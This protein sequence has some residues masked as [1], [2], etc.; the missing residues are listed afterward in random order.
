MAPTFDAIGLAVADMTA[1]LA[2]YR[3]LGLEA[4]DGAE[5]EPHAEAALPGGLRLMFDTHELIRSMDP[6]WTPLPEGGA[7]L[8]F[9][10]ADPD[11]VDRVYAEMVEAGYPSEK[12]PWDAFWGQRY[13]VIRDPDGNQ[14]DLFAP[15]TSA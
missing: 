5:T 12:E 9:R 14:V 1:T 3:R 8:A 13:A 2:F 4:P 7:S 15:L 10:C 6:E 11:D